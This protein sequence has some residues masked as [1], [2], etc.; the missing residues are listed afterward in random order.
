MHRAVLAAVVSLLL[1][2]QAVAQ[3]GRSGDAV[4]KHQADGLAF[5]GPAAVSLLKVFGGLA[6]VGV[7][8]FVGWL[9][10]RRLQ[11]SPTPESDPWVRAQLARQARDG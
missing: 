2:G 6:A 7:A 11:P 1:A 8:G 4:S 5:F 3:S 10:L 9:L